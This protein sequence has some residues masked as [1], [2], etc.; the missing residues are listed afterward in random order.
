MDK[1]PFSCPEGFEEKRERWSKLGYSRTCN[2]SKDGK[3]EAWDNGYKN[4]EGF[5][6]NGQE[7]GKWVWYNKD[8]S[9]YRIVEYKNGKE[10][11]NQLT[12]N[13]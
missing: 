9:V 2:P 10:I 5:Y 13:K 7:D 11:S 8:G 6:K 3:W 12:E 1:V 4:I